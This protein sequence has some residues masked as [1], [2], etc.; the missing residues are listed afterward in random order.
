MAWTCLTA[1]NFL[2]VCLAGRE[3]WRPSMVAQA[4][5][6]GKTRQPMAQRPD[7]WWKETSSFAFEQPIIV[8]WSLSAS[9]LWWV[10][11]FFFFFFSHFSFSFF[12]LF[13]AET[14]AGCAA[15][16][17]EIRNP[18]LIKDREERERKRTHLDIT[19]SHLHCLVLVGYFSRLAGAAAG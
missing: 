2:C 14:A 15:W 8:A 5:N 10:R 4:A 17:M 1:I 9:P 6:M 12:G 18:R 19:S 3:G 7:L 13:A 11:P 16:W